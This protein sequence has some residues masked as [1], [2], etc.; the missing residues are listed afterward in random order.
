LCLS[1][2]TV[3]P[4]V[5]PSGISTDDLYHFNIR[6]WIRQV[7]P[8]SRK[9]PFVPAEQF[10]AGA[11]PLPGREKVSEAKVADH[12]VSQLGS[13]AERPDRPHQARHPPDITLTPDP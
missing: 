1:S 13:P 4:N 2:H 11:D 12:P 10:D 8:A 3:L 9:R 5:C 7:S 6:R